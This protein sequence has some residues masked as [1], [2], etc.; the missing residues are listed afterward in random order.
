MPKGTASDDGAV[1]EA[2]NGYS[3]TKTSEGWR[4]THHIIAEETLGRAIQPNERVIFIDKNRKNLVAKN[5]KVVPQGRSSTR[6]RIA[7]LE[8]R[9]EEL[10]AELNELRKSLEWPENNGDEGNGHH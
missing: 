8:A 5:I 3:Y 6:R 7:A 4:L 2:K 1:K 10:Q 9:I